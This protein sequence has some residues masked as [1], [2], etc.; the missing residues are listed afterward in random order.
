MKVSEPAEQERLVILEAFIA[1]VAERGYE[2][3]ELRAVFARAGVDEVA[4]LR[5]FPDKEECFLAAW[6]FLT[7][8]FMP[9]VLAAFESK[10]TWR[11]QIRGVG[12]ALA[13]YLTEHPDHARILCLEGRV[14]GPRAWALLDRNVEVFAELIDLGRQEMADPD[15]LTRATAEGLAGAIHEQLILYVSRGDGD[16]LSQLMGPMMYMVMRPYL[17]DEVALEELRRT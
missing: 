2:D 10:E 9:K 13:E 4:F 17:G 15:S 14:P 11:E 12:L 3:T 8:C 6:D 1:V 16:Q 7:D 5:H